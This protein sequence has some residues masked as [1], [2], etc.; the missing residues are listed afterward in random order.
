MISPSSV[1]S[2]SAQL[3]AVGSLCLF[4][5]GGNSHNG[6]LVAAQTEF[7][8]Q[9]LDRFTN[10]TLQ[11]GGCD[12]ERDFDENALSTF[13]I[14]VETGDQ[15]T[16]PRTCVEVN[17]RERCFFTYVPESCKSSDAKVPLVVDTHS[18]LSCPRF[19]IGY[20]GW[21]AQAEENCFVVVFPIGNEPSDEIFST[22]WN[23]PGFAQ[24]PEFGNGI[25]TSQCCCFAPDDGL[26]PTVNTTE[27]NDPLFLKTAI[28]TVLETF[29]TITGD[30]EIETKLSIDADRVYMTGH[31]NGCVA[32]LSMAALY[33]DTIA[34]VACHAGAL[35]TPFDAPD[36]SP[37]PI[38]L[39]HGKFDDTFP[40][41]GSSFPIPPNVNPLFPDGG[42]LGSWSI[43][44]IQDY[45]SAKN[46]CEIKAVENVTSMDGVIGSTYRGTGCKN[47]ATIEVVTLNDSGHRPMLI[48][49]PFFKAGVASA[50]NLTTIDTTALAWD[51]LSKQSK[52]KECKDDAGKFELSSNKKKDCK[53]AGKKPEKR[54]K[55]CKKKLTND[56][57]GRKKVK[58]FCPL[59]CEKCD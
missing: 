6:V 44:Q 54:D 1:A 13:F 53:W 12:P 35:A 37:V 24:S 46:G 9:Y 21:R 36:Y 57:E 7:I 45:L 29:E 28:D 8:P 43:P 14:D 51:F 59:T 20:S 40:Y 56:P 49:D 41:D 30:A 58:D 39:V 48:D 17:G 18:L 10:F 11:Y 25:T 31:S 52:S 2:A 42:L 26:L 23:N 15:K 47:N 19:H 33:S 32:S 55:R 22:C 50:E 34:G 27:Y 16:V 4:L 38:W 5:L 3:L